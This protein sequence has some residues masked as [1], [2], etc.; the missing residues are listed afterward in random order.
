MAKRTVKKKEERALSACMLGANNAQIKR[1]RRPC[2]VTEKKLDSR[3]SFETFYVFLI[4]YLFLLD[5]NPF[6]NKS[7]KQ[8]SIIYCEIETK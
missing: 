3:T 2:Y 1:M 6:G 5:N 8:K 7:V 4:F